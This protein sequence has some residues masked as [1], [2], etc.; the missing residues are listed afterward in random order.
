MSASMCE[1]VRLQEFTHGL[2]RLASKT[3]SLSN[4]LFAVGLEQ[5]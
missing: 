2:F 5:I 4:K 1:V 3:S